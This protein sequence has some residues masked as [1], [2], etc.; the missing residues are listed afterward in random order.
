MKSSTVVTGNVQFL[1]GAPKMFAGVLSLELLRML[2]LKCNG[3]NKPAG[4]SLLEFAAIRVVVR[5]PGNNPI[6]AYQRGAYP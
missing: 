2:I 1:V 3:S 6:R 5:S 4:G